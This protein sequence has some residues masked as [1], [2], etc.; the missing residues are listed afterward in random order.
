MIRECG[1]RVLPVKPW[2]TTYLHPVLSNISV[3]E[4]CTFQRENIVSHPFERRQCCSVRQ[5][6]ATAAARLTLHV[7][8]QQ[9]HNLLSA[10]DGKVAVFSFIQNNNLIYRPHDACCDVVLT[11]KC[12]RTVKN[13]KSRLGF[14]KG[15]RISNRYL[16]G[17]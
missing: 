8:G 17:T 11:L 1:W 9:I 4:V 10:D 13:R 15:K 12:I 2:K 16:T 3:T 5:R 6:Q 7:N 14:K